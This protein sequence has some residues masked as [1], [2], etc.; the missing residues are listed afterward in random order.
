VGCAGAADADSAVDGAATLII[1]LP[2]P[3]APPVGTVTT[4]GFGVQVTPG[5]SPVVGQVTFT[6][7]VNPP[8]G[9]KVIVD[10]L[11]APAVTVA[12]LPPMVNEP[13]LPIVPVKEKFK[14]LFPPKAMGLGSA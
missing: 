4:K 14:M 3:F 11:L 10:V 9:V 6:L 8:V 13:V 12:A 5:G 7:P 2:V 1:R